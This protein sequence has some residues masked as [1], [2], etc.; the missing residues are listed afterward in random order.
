MA[1]QFDKLTWLGGT[2]PKER[3]AARERVDLTSEITRVMN[4]NKGLT[5][6]RGANNFDL[7]GDH[8]KEWDIFFTLLDEHLATLHC[9]HVSVG[10]NATNLSRS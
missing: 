8:H 2:R 5:G 10:C 7:T 1:I 6:I 9:A 4:G 3:P